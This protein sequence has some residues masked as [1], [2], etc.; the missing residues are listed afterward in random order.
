MRQDACH[1]NCI[2]RGGPGFSGLVLQL[3][4]YVWRTGE[5]KGREGRG[6]EGRGGRRG[7]EGMIKRQVCFDSRKLF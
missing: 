6:G 7:G 3:R 5:G 1:A 4:M 2:M